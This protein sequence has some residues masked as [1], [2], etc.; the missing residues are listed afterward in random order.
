MNGLADKA[1][2]ADS[3][4]ATKQWKHSERISFQSI[5]EAAA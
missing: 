4:D 2:I 1:I 5:G 3:Y